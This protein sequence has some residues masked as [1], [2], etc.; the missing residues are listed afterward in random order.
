M[1][2]SNCEDQTLIQALT[3]GGLKAVKPDVY[4]IFKMAEETYRVETS[5]K[6]LLKIDTKQMVTT[7]LKSVDIP[8][9]YNGIA[10]NMFI[11]FDKELKENLHEKMISLYLRVRAFVTAED[12]IQKYRNEQKKTKSKGLRKS[13]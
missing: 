5:T 6:I 12:T 11:S 3:R 8:S 4:S 13:L 10:G 9:L 2:T 1:I 7:L